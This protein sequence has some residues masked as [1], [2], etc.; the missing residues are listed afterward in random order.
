MYTA[1]RAKL[2]EQLVA[3]KVS[4]HDCQADELDIEAALNFASFLLANAKSLY[5]Q[6][7]VE[8]KRRLLAVLSPSGFTF[9]EKKGFRTVTSD[10][11]FNGLYQVAA[12]L[13]KDGVTDGI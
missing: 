8:Q 3:A 1:R 6:L 10:C 2:E 12:V 11:V 9:D 7:S 4:L 5:V 13:V